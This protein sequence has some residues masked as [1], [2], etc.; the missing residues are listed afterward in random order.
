MSPRSKYWGDVSASA[1]HLWSKCCCQD[2]SPLSHRDRRPCACLTDTSMRPMRC[3]HPVI[4][5]KH[6]GGSDAG[7]SQVVVEV[8]L[9]VALHCPTSASVSNIT[10]TMVEH[11]DDDEDDD[12]DDARPIRDAMLRA[13]SLEY[14]PVSRCLGIACLKKCIEDPRHELRKYGANF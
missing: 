7:P 13:V 2:V 10:R 14:F 4:T 9:S 11:V 12:D 8:L 5:G 3:S 1:Q 6:V